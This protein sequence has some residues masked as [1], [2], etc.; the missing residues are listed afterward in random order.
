MRSWLAICVA[1]V[2]M[3]CVWG[4]ADPFPQETPSPIGTGNASGAQAQIDLEILGGEYEGTYSAVATNACV[5]DTAQDTFSVNYAD[6]FASEDFVA[7]HLV[8]RNATQ[9]Q[10]DS[11]ADFKV[12]IGLDGAANITSFT[13]DPTAGFG[14]GDAFLDVTDTDATLDLSATA[15]DESLVELTVICE[16]P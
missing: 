2:A 6:D 5:N 1:L 8:L 4:P 10:E 9:A 3:A 14:E 11:S 12:D 16:S 15:A 7:L 13:L